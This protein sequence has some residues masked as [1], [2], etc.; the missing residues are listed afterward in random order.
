MLKKEEE[1]RDAAVLA[2]AEEILLALRTAPKTR[3]IDNISLLVA[4]LDHKEMLAA[5]MDEINERSGGQR[6]SFSR[7]AKGVMASPAIILIGARTAPCGLNCAWCGY[8]TCAEKTEKAPQAPCVFGP[9]DLGIAAGVAAVKLAEKHIDN[10]MM[11]SIGMAALA[12]DWFPPET[13]VALGFPMSVT[14]KNP[15][16]DRK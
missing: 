10:R 11:F 7:D 2:A 12:L 5:K 13:T 6:P 16:F 15:F 14:G 1:I 4:S 9:V 3:G 8:P